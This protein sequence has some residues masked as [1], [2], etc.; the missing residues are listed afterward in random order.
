MGGGTVGVVRVAG[1]ATVTG[2][3]AIW[4]FVGLVVLTVFNDQIMNRYAIWKA[5]DTGFK[6]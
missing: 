5:L 3:P 6:A 4:A 1:L 2:G